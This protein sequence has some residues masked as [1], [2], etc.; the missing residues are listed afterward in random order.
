MKKW[1]EEP[2]AVSSK[3]WNLFYK[4]RDE[5]NKLIND[6]SQY[7]YHQLAHAIMDVLCNNHDFTETTLDK[8]ANVSLIQ[9]C[10][11][12]R[13]DIDHGDI[14]AAICEYAATL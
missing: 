8:L 13:V 11:N 2:V 9:L 3:R 4:L 14:E 10:E 1:Y 6:F 12:V 7:A 5:Y